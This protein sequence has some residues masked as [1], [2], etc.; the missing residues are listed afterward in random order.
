MSRQIHDS[1]SRKRLI[2]RRLPDPTE[3]LRASLVERYTKCGK[4]GCKCMEGH[5]HGPSYYISVTLAPGKTKQLYVR[6]QDLDTVREWIANYDKMWKG[7]MEISEVNFEVLRT[8]HPDRKPKP[9]ALQQ[10]GE[11]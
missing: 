7:L 11:S 9:R 6:R 1:R 8:L 4:P 2:A 5:M 10:K 3:I